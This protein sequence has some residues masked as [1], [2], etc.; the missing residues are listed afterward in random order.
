MLDEFVQ[1]FHDYDRR[2]LGEIHVALLRS[3]IKDIEDVARTPSSTGLG[4]NQN[5][6]ANPGGGH[7]QIVEG[8]YAWGFDIRNWQHH[9]NPLTWPEIL[10]QFALSAGFGPKLKKM[11]IEKTYLSDELRTSFGIIQH[12]HI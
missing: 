11:S 1:A 2:L 10:R 3:I 12:K 6:A 7:P 5:A 9:L 4:V 8:A